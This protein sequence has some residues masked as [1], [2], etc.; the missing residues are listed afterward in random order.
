[1]RVVVIDPRE[2]IVEER[3]LKPGRHR[4]ETILGDVAA[5]GTWLKGDAVYV[6][7]W[8]SND[9]DFF[10]LGADG[11]I[12]GRAVVAGAAAGYAGWRASTTITV[13]EV[14]SSVTWS[15]EDAERPF[16][17]LNKKWCAHLPEREA[18]DLMQARRWE[19]LRNR[20]SL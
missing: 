8:P 10:R 16:V 18:F 14:L 3:E 1:M 7:D 19:R 5:F 6:C 2:R 13:P 4:I 9:A 17:W 15:E 11:W 12:A 20:T